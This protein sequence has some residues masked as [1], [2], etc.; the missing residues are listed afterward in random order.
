AVT[1]WRKLWRE[2]M[3]FDAIEHVRDLLALVG[4]KCSYVDQRLH[5]FGTRE[6][7]DRTGIGVSRQYDRTFDP[8]QAAV[9]GGDVVRKRCRRKRS[10]EGFHGL[11]LECRYDPGPA[12]S[13]RPGPMGQHYAH[14]LR[15]H[16]AAPG[17]AW[18]FGS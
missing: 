17:I 7:Y 18:S 15:R 4:S 2:W 6:S 9:E 13:T 5:A 3:G 16:P 1:V 14:A 12:R 10:R 8:V 11:G